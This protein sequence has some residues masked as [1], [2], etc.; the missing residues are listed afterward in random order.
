MVLP[1]K[2]FEFSRGGRTVKVRCLLDLGSQRSYL[3]SKLLPKFNLSPADLY[4][5]ECTIKTF[6]GQQ[7]RVISQLGVSIRVSKR[8]KL[9]LPFLVD[10]N[11]Q[12]DFHTAGLGQAIS[13]LKKAGVKL[14]DSAFYKETESDFV[15][16]IQGLIGADILPFL[17]NF[18]LANIKNS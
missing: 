10:S 4:S 7:K 17:G 1:T 8:Q 13:N 14:A 12:L 11:L 16:N 2:T 18:T 3:S 5:Q 9:T 15:N 6:V